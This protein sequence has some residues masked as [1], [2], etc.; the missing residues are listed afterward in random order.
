[1]PP[2]QA[3]Q[4]LESYA[5]ALKLE[6]GTVAWDRFFE[7]AATETGRIPADVLEDQQT[8]QKL[9]S[10]YR[11]LASCEGR[12]TRAG[13]GRW[14]FETWADTLDA[15][16]TLPQ[17]VRRLI[18]ATGKDIG[19]IEFPAH[20]QV[21]RPGWDGIVEAGEADA[22][23]PAGTSVWE[24]GVEKNPQKKAEED[25]TKRTK[26]PL[27]LDREKTTIRLRHAPK[28]QKKEEWRRTKQDLGI[29]KD[30]RVYDSASLEEWLEQS[31]AVDA[32]L[33]GLLGKKPT[34]L[35]T[36]D[37]YWANLQAMTDPSLKPEV[38]LASREEQVEELE[39]WLDGPPGTMVIEARSP[40]EAID[41]VAAFSRAPSRAEWLAA[42]ALIVETR[43]AWRDVSAAADAE[44]LL[45]AH[46]SLSIEPEMV[47]EAVRQG[48]RVLVSSSQAPREQV[49]SLKL[50]R[51]Y[52][53]DLEKALES[54][55]L[56]EER[57]ELRARSR[58]KPDRVEAPPRT[59][60]R[61]DSARV[62]PTAGSRGVRADA[63]GRKL[64]WD[65]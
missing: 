40:V 21:Q 30:V 4:L 7:L 55:G 54:S 9:P 34:G 53:Y 35:T 57:A 15:R 27:G 47:A 24:L 36:I 56:D 48:H 29:W 45:I 14:T 43:D 64:G 20:E 38:F 17:L 3:R 46:P 44:L 31:P 12:G 37:D 61:D 16:A 1:M 13:L 28:W 11:R 2:P 51:A 5:K 18:R 41:F 62:E 42:R 25:F 58:R 6:S 22:F 39:A 65:L 33:A 10:L 59:I 50:P 26:D 49:S 19:A 63:A 32:W 23:V 8:I 60:S 52:R